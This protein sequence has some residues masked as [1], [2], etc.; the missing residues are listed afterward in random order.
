M[1]QFIFGL[2]L[3]RNLGMYME[4]LISSMLRASRQDIDDIAQHIF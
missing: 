1:P 4:L 3:S 2:S